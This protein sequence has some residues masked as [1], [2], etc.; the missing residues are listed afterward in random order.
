MY[1]CVC[2]RRRCGRCLFGGHRRSLARSRARWLAKL[3]SKGAETAHKVKIPPTRTR[4]QMV[5]VLVAVAAGAAGALAGEG[6]HQK[7]TLLLCYRSRCSFCCSC[8][9]TTRGKG[10]QWWTRSSGRD[11]SDSQEKEVLCSNIGQTDA[12]NCQISRQR[13]AK[14]ME[15]DT[16]PINQITRR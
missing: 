7:M 4:N 5:R 2:V 12:G 8:N 1:C 9:E 15:R 6:S 11:I 10:G 14:M 16:Q 3:A 13:S